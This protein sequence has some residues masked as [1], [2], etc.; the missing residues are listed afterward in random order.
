MI[1]NVHTWLKM[2]MYIFGLYF[3]P[4]PYRHSCTL[5]PVVPFNIIVKKLKKTILPLSYITKLKK[6]ILTLFGYA[7]YFLDEDMI[8]SLCLMINNFKQDMYKTIVFGSQHDL[9]FIHM[10]INAYKY[11]FVYIFYL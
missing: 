2:F 6:S 9:L 1:F 8:I 5:P 7:I 11:T 3:V 10:Y 4:L